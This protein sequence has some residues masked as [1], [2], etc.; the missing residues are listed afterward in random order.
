MVLF[1]HNLQFDMSE[2]FFKAHPRCKKADSQSEYAC[3]QPQRSTQGRHKFDQQ[4]DGN[5]LTHACGMGN[6]SEYGNDQEIGKR[7]V[8]PVGGELEKLA[9]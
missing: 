3:E 9:G 1:R 2:V 5:M 4:R 8:R 6:R 7:V